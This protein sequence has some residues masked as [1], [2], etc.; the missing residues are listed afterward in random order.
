MNTTE[1]F[2]H[3]RRLIVLVLL[4]ICIGLPQ[5][6]C[7][8]WQAPDRPAQAKTPPQIV[9]FEKAAAPGSGLYWFEASNETWQTRSAALGYHLPAT[10]PPPGNDIFLPAYRLQ[11]DGQ[12]QAIS[13]PAQAAPIFFQPIPINQASLE[14]LM[15]I[16][17]IGRRLAAAIIGYRDEVGRIS[18]RASLLA[19]DGIGEKKAAIIADY[20]RFE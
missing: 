8:F 9:W 17:G 4:G 20:V 10:L 3:D 12:A 5:F 18:G 2:Q 7:A 19:I 13:S 16:P 1:N 14:T 15:V 6:Y 11:A